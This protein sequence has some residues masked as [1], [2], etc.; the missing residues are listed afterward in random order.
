MREKILITA[1]KL[2]LACLA[3]LAVVGL[4]MTR[5]SA[6]SKDDTAQ[7]KITNI[8]GGPTV[9]LYKIGEGVYN[10]NGDSFINFKY[11]EG[12][13]LTETGP[14]SQEITTIANGINTGKIKPFSTENVS[15]SNGTATYNARGASV[16]IALLT[17]A[18]DGRTY[19]PILLA[20]SYNGEGNLVTKNIDS[21]S[22][23]LYG[24]TSVAKSSLPSIT[25]KVTGTIDD[26]NKKTT[27][28]GSVLSYSLTFE[29]P[30]YT[31]E[32]VNKTVY[33][34]DN[35]SEGLTFNFNSLTVEWKGKMANITEDG[36]VM[37]ENTKIGI[38]K[39]VNNGFNLSF[40]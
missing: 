33:V 39:E 35:M 25:K 10:T 15:I 6:L 11:A 3:I 27:S 40:I 8:E 13:S 23:Y 18:T 26:V 4:G 32:A 2:M 28:L 1:K 37:V 30:S 22:N 19:N 5:V 34:S 36:S 16:Y 7:L 17:G 9:T 21:K 31:K 20:A 38:A 29:L 24:Q 12:V 14:T